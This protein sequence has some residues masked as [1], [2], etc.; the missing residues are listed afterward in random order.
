[1]DLATLRTRLPAMTRAALGE[2]VCV[3]PMVE[4]KL[5]AIADAER[6]TQ[7]SVPARFDFAP[8]VEQLG[9]G[10]DVPERARVVSPHASVSFALSDLQ[11]LPGQGDQVERLHPL[12]G[13]VERYRIERTL[14]PQPA[15]LLAMISRVS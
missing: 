11:W 14:E 4:G 13:A 8:D 2:R 7:V 5:A 6:A 10:R 1:M 15:V 12:T 9:G 3:V